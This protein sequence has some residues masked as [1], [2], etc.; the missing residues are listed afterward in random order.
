MY[1]FSFIFS[2]QAIM[3][4]LHFGVICHRRCM[5][6]GIPTECQPFYTEPTMAFYWMPAFY[7]LLVIHNQVLKNYKFSQH[8]FTKRKCTVWTKLVVIINRFIFFYFK[9]T[10]FQLKKYESNTNQME[11]EWLWVILSRGGRYF[12]RW[13]ETEFDC[14]NMIWE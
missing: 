1:I 6:S 4:F 14:F 2:F 9:R 3:S 12:C 11:P 10:R 5:I 7:T 8:L 13:A